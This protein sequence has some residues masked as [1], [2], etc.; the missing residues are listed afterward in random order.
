MPVKSNLRPGSLP[1]IITVTNLC[2]SR[3]FFEFTKK[4]ALA[5]LMV[6]KIHSSVI[7]SIKKGNPTSSIGFGHLYV[8]DRL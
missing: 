7:F 5:P 1:Q 4:N 3:S 6:T 2:H 8:K